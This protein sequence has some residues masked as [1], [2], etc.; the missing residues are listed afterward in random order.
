VKFIFKVVIGIVVLLGIALGVGVY[1]I[2]SIAKKAI[3]YGGTEALGVTTSLDSIDIAL[4]EGRTSM[5]N[6]AIANPEGFEAQQLMHLGKGTLAV[7]LKSLT[8]DTIIIPEISFSDLTLNIEQKDRTS[9]VKTLMDSMKARTSADAAKPEK[10]AAQDGTDAKVAKEFIIERVVL[11]NIKV[12]AKISAM[13][14]VLTNTSVTIPSIQLKGIGKSSDGLPME[15]VIK[16]LV[17][18]ILNASINNSGALSSSLSGL[19]E[20][21]SINVDTLKK[22]L[23]EQIQQKA[24]AG[25]DKATKKLIQDTSLPEGS[26]ALIKQ[27]AEEASSKLKGLFNKE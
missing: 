8:K 26:D 12:N 2:D 10:P 11:N 1:Y 17:N 21:K 16:E 19:L 25:M 4:L 13:N 14:N 27:K 3:E 24:G 9:N 7:N 15:A 18:A 23:S 6:L 5:Q 22:N 20:G